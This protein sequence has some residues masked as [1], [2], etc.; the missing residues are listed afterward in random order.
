M[1]IRIFCKMDKSQTRAALAMAIVCALY[2]AMSSALTP[3]I[4]PDITINT[5]GQSSQHAILGAFLSSNCNADMHLYKD[6]P[7]T[8]SAGSNWVS[9]FCTMSSSADVPASLQGKKVLYNHRLKGGSVWG[10]IPVGK[11]WNVEF[12]NIRYNGGSHCTQVMSGYYEC[13]WDDSRSTAIGTLADGSIDCPQ[14]TNNLSSSDKKTMC[15]PPDAGISALEPQVNGGDSTPSG[16]AY[17][18]SSETESL[19]VGTQFGVVYGVT[20]TDDV[21]SALQQTQGTTGTPSLTKDEVT[22]ILSGNIKGWKKL[23]PNLSGIS[24]SASS[25]YMALCRGRAGS[26]VQAAQGVHFLNNPC[27]DSYGGSGSMSAS[28]LS[29]TSYKVIENTTMTEESDCLNKGFNGGLLPSTVSRKYGAIGFF[30]I[31][32]QPSAT[33]KW[34]YVAIDGIEPTIE[35]AISGKYNN[36]YEQTMQWKNSKS[37]STKDAL[38]M[39]LSAS[40]NPMIITSA[41]LLGAVALPGHYDWRDPATYPTSR[42]TRD[43]NSC[44]SSVAM[45]Y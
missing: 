42:S 17:L 11:G 44:K 41:G 2:P 15:A 13:T 39:L 22:G 31:D 38:N 18:T 4:T 6:K 12:M 21:Y 16:W 3:S 9:Y 25:A 29:T 23:D 1:L 19:V 40:R 10:V 32:N 5:V 7:S 45:P 24:S 37:G 20:V 26:G 33:D 27:S 8:G 43:G 36:V 30:S 35:N 14:N 34:K 28:G